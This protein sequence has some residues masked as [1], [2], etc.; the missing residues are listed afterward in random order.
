LMTFILV[1][2]AKF[3]CKAKDS[4]ILLLKEKSL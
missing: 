4:A 2:L 3:R 1:S